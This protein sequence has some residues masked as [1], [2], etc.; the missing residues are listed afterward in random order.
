MNRRVSPSVPPM[1]KSLRNTLP[2][3]KSKW[4]L[5]PST[6]MREPLGSASQRDLTAPSDQNAA[7][8]A[9]GIMP[10][11]GCEGLE[12]LAQ[13]VCESSEATVPP[14]PPPEGTSLFMLPPP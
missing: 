10:L 4:L 5:V 11:A 14:P 8:G 1:R 6:V 3:G 2:F 13:P 12:L 7:L 9:Y